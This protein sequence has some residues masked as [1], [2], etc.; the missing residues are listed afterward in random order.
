M[1]RKKA[2]NLSTLVKYVLVLPAVFHLVHGIFEIAKDEA[3]S[4]RRKFVYVVMAA[5]F[6]LA[7]LASIWLCVTAL[8]VLWLLSMHL[9]PVAAISITLLLNF[10]LLTIVGLLLSIVK[11][12]PLLPETRKVIKDLLSS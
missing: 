5:L 8:I 6:A 11:L 9:T 3:A 12:D 4:I 10:L 7:L 1:A 2:S